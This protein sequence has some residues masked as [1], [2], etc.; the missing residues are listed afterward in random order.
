MKFTPLALQGVWL[1][2][3]VRY[4]DSRGYFCETWRRDLFEQHV[5]H[6]EFVQDNESVSAYGVVRGLHYQRGSA[7]QA[8]L[9]R[10]SRGAVVDVIVDLRHGSPTYG[11]H[12]AV[13]L[14]A[15]NS[16]QLFVP[17]GFAHGFAVVSRDSVAQFQYKVDNAYC[18]SAEMTVPFD[19]AD[20]AI[21]W[22]IDRKDM[23]LSDKDM[24]GTPFRNLTPDILPD[25]C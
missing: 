10:V 15:E 13:E 8:K 2:E 25:G 3:P 19:D 23:L 11:R 7:A 12:L 16:R 18:P 1:I 17:R 14:S 22:P 6:V 5:G 9:V 4:G 24:H 21:V 20:L